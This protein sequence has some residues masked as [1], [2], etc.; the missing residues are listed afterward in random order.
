VWKSAAQ[1]LEF[2]WRSEALKDGP[3]LDDTS[4]AYLAS[5]VQERQRRRRRHL[6]AAGEAHDVLQ[7]LAAQALA[8]AHAPGQRVDALGRKF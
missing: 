8:L 5:S 1:E 3:Q 2:V 6:H 7:R 4:H